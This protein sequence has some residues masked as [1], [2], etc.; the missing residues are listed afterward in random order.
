MLER[1]YDD[2]FTERRGRSGHGLV[3]V[4]AGITVKSIEAKTGK[5]YRVGVDIKQVKDIEDG[6]LMNLPP[7]ELSELA[8]QIR[9]RIVKDIREHLFES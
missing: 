5:V 4:R 9:R 3:D 6:T 2:V 7:E 8:S 1:S